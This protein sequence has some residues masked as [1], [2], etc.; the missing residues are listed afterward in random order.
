MCHCFSLSFSCDLCLDPFIKEPQSLCPLIPKEPWS[1]VHS[2][3]SLIFSCG[4]VF[5][6]FFDITSLFFL[7]KFF[8]FSM[9]VKIWHMLEVYDC[10][11]Q[12]NL[13][14][15]LNLWLLRKVMHFK[16]LQYCIYGWMFSM[17][18]IWSLEQIQLFAFLLNNGK[19]ICL[20]A[21]WSRRP[22]L[23]NHLKKMLVS[24]TLFSLKMVL[25]AFAQI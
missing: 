11:M 23:T 5:K 9:D 3:S 16:L 18:K 10:W 4:I 21:T 25:R 20:W 7:L 24:A 1:S 14:V 12:L 2:Y 15:W 8:P 6:I 17:L 22:L 19:M 13:L